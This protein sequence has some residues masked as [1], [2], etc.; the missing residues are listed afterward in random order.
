MS[1]ISK[2]KPADPD[3]QAAAG[4]ALLKALL[5]EFHIAA[6]DG[7]VCAWRAGAE[8]RLL[9]ALQFASVRKL[10]DGRLS[11][12]SVGRIVNWLDQN[13]GIVLDGLFIERGASG[14]CRVRQVDVAQR[15][16]GRP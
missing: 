5:A 1:F 4:A 12:A 13:A 9:L 15:R 6:F 8:P 3:W 7:A 14:W 16:G 11:S 2:S 10:R